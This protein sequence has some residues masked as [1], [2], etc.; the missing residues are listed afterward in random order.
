M[1]NAEFKLGLFAR[2]FLL[3]ALLMLASLA[4]WLHVFWTLEREPRAA[5]IA[6]QI[7]RAV[8]LTQAT[9]EFVQADA[10]RTLLEA[11]TTQ[12]DLKLLGPSESQNLGNV[13]DDADWRTVIALVQAKLG[14]DT[15]LA[16]T[17]PFTGLVWV[18][19]PDE[20]WLG[21]QA[22]PMSLST[23]P[24]WVSWIAAAALLSMVGAAVAVGYLNSPLS[25]LSRA[26]QQLSQGQTPD[27][28]PEAGPQEI[29]QLNASFNRMVSELQQ[30]EADRNLMLAGISHDLRT[31]L[32]RM[33]LEVEMSAMSE[34]QRR[35]IDEDLSQI[36]QTIGQ[37]LQYAKPASNPP[38][39]PVNLLDAIED[40]I[41]QVQPMLAGSQDILQYRSRTSAYCMIDREDFSR[42][43]TN[44]VENARRY[45]KSI[46]GSVAIEIVVQSRGDRLHI[47]V[48]DRG[49]GIA[50][51]DIERLLR[52][53]SR[54]ETARTGGAG[55]GLGLA[56]V[57]RLL[58]RAGGRL[59]L[60]P[61]EAGGLTARIDL[62]RAKRPRQ[63][64]T[65]GQSKQAVAVKHNA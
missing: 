36:D 44:L 14:S 42:C 30:A 7:V 50:S 2:T 64:R 62:P 25:R 46:D 52:P 49:P 65:G 20:H 51:Q 11:I 56:I 3:L 31:P 61:R 27:P 59:R 4:A 33:R 26:A 53:F 8:Q 16:A 19:L 1:V 37:L 10:Q 35:A 54:G 40:V 29:Q 60:L 9:R 28:L 39:K 48:R 32:A 45:G 12:T 18:Q 55:S 13:P 58:A 23:A 15:K 63:H 24:E 43:V 38:S 34:E 5:Q 22:Q 21:I 6:D 17:E 41:R 57:E 47:D